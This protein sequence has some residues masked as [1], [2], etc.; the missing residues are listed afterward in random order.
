MGAA[1]FTGQVMPSWVVSARNT[2]CHAD[3]GGRQGCLPLQPGHIFCRDHAPLP[4]AG[5][6]AA[7]GSLMSKI[8][9]KFTARPVKVKEKSIYYY[10]P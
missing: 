2:A 9:A 8:W 5:R 6:N 10:M 1:G 7:H 4:E 3:P